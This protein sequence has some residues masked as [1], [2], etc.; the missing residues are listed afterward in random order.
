LPVASACFSTAQPELFGLI[1]FERRRAG[2]KRWNDRW[3]GT[4][5]RKITRVVFTKPKEANMANDPVIQIA[6]SPG[7]Q[8]FPDE[9]YLL[10][11]S[12]AVFHG[13]LSE[14][15][16]KWNEVPLPQ[17]KAFQPPSSGR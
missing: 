7:T 3:S 15:G 1:S 4:S 13:S 12:G 10:Y 9:V 6:V 14:E 16:W 5:K 8:E 2:T 17:G 11:Q